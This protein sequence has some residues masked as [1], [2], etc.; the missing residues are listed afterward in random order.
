M[1]YVE[2][3]YNESTEEIQKSNN[4]IVVH[5]IGEVKN[6]GVVILKEGDRIVDAIE[7]A[8]GE[9]ENA[10]LNKLNLAYILQD[11]EKLYVPSIYEE[12][13]EQEYITKESG[14]N[15]IIKG[16]GNME[17]EK[18][19]MININTGDI[20]DLTTL[21]GIGESTAKK[22]I[23]YREEN[24]KFEKIEDIKNVPGIGNAKFEN[25]KNQIIV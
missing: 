4:T 21:P 3:L 13:N 15:T 20:E 6:K 1:N 9:T 17:Q 18:G 12:D 19:K 24:G 11:G 5:I 23:T 25:I 8:G 16:D 2:E 22:I 7:A 10:D 14:E